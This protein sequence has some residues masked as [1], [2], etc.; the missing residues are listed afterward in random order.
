[1]LGA[2]YFLLSLLCTINNLDLR[3][4]VPFLKYDSKSIWLILKFSLILVYTFCS[5]LGKVLSSGGSY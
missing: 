5:I 3:L 2:D 1:M 4:A